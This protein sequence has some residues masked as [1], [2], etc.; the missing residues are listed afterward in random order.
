MSAVL[1]CKEHAPTKTIIHRIHDVVN[2]TG[3]NALQLYV[4]NFK[5]ADLTL[6]GTVR[7]ANQMT[8][9]AK[10]SG[11]PVQA[12]N[13]RAS[14]TTTPNGSWA[15]PRNADVADPGSHAQHPGDKIC[16]TCGIDIALRWW[17]IDN[18]QERRLTNGH[19]GV[20]GSE[21][22]KFVEQRKFQCHK[23][24]KLRKTPRSP[25]L[26]L[27]TG[28]SPPPAELARPQPLEATLMAPVPPLRGS[29]PP[30]PPPNVVDY[31]DG[32]HMSHPLSWPQ[33]P[34]GSHSMPA[35]S[36]PP[37]IPAPVHAPAQVTGHRPPPMAHPYP[38]APPPPP[39]PGRTTAYPEWAPHRPGSQHNSPPRHIN[40]GPPPPLLHGGPP[41]PQPPPVSNLSALRPPAMA[42]PPPAAPLPGGH[43]HGH[44]YSNGLPPSPR[45]MSG[46]TAP[47]PYVPPYH[48][49]HSGHGGPIHPPAHLMNNGPPPPPPPP[50]PP[51]SDAFSHGLHPQRPS[52][53]PAS[54]ASPPIVR[55]GLP[56]P[57]PPQ[58]HELPPSSAPMA[59][60]PPESR[61]ATAASTNPSLRNL[62]S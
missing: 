17:P 9:A 36:T 28:P 60:R 22:Q 48:S 54:H 8:T 41:P 2:E 15:P 35:V 25:G 12:W 29:T 7:K 14:T 42:G 3:L 61:P 45:R 49:G 21:A 38:P 23:C 18:F 26:T 1:W 19:H 10:I 57:P 43:Q 56:P 52:Y 31:R 11:A 20:I 59:P 27:R 4:Q 46:P 16:I 40:G 33:P 44:G 6:T 55:N 37:L 30:P 32:R 62:L 5:Q 39:P 13:R 24:H 53:P 47:A 58:P 34:P 51:R 50:P